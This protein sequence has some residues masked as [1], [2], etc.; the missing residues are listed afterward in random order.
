[1]LKSENLNIEVLKTTNPN[2]YTHHLCC[3]TVNVP[4]LPP[5]CNL[6][7][8]PLHSKKWRSTG[9]ST[10]PN[11][12]KR[13]GMLCVYFALSHFSHVVSYF[14]LPHDFSSS[15]WFIALLCKVAF[16]EN[17]EWRPTTITSPTAASFFSLSTSLSLSLSVFRASFIFPLFMHGL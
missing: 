11:K 16:G 8:E 13:D 12:W 10:S 4:L 7:N 2:L 15:L 9:E 1:M 6:Q 17:G 3:L 5:L 14:T